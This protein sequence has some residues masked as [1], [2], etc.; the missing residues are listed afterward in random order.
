VGLIFKLNSD[1]EYPV[2]RELLLSQANVH[3]IP[4]DQ[5]HPERTDLHKLVSLIHD[6][7]YST[8]VLIHCTHGRDRTGLVCG[9]WRILKNGW[10]P[11][12]AI[13]EMHAF[14]AVGLI[15]LADREIV[16]ALRE[17]KP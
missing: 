11:D 16:E 5:W 17:L 8:S 6:A 13:A 10:S 14:G 2:D 12:K 15:E 1:N 3:S 4:V 7:L 9:A